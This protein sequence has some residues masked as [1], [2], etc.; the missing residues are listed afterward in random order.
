MSHFM[1]YGQET[2]MAYYTASGTCMGNMGDKQYS[3]RNA[4]KTYFEVTL[5]NAVHCCQ[6]QTQLHS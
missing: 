6:H 1:P 4:I 3:M 5:C 2:D